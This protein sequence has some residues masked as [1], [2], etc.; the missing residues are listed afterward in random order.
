MTNRTIVTVAA[1]GAIGYVQGPERN[2]PARCFFFLREDVMKVKD[3][4]EKHSVP[5]RAYANPGE[6]IAL[7]HAMKNFLGH[8]AAL[9]AVIRAVVDGSLAPVGYTNRF[10]GITGSLFVA[11]DLRKYRP[12][13]GVKVPPEGFVNYGEAAAVLGVKVREIRGLVAHGIINDAAEYRFGLSKLL[14]AADV[15]RFADGYVAISVLARRFHVNSRS[16]ARYLNESGTPLLAIPLP[17]AGR[18]HAF[19][20]R[21]D[22]ATQIQSPSRRMLRDAAE[23]RIVAARKQR[24]AEYRLA[25]EAAS[26]KAMRRQLR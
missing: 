5:V 4:F 1:G 12:V 26:G 17:D 23:R 13:S 22:I 15:Q 7:R 20:L 18:G 3:A 14:P 11:K 9:A 16:L 24:W 2:F 19:F 10:Q 21:K 8:D 6:L 25:K